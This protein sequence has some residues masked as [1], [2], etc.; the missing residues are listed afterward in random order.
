MPESPDLALNR[1]TPIVTREAPVSHISAAEAGQPYQM[2]ANALDKVG[3]GLEDM[4]VPLAEQ[5]GYKAVTRDAEGNIQ[6]ERMPIFGK[7]GV[8]YQ[9]AVKVAALAEGEGAAKRADIAMRSDYRD[10]PQG[11]QVAAQAFK[12]QTVKQ[13]TAAAGAEVGA[14]MGQAIDNKTTLT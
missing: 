10:N 13:Y 1:P 7:A 5:A 4:A 8:A 14:A 3:Q 9:H 11:Y 6:V 2:L 12:E